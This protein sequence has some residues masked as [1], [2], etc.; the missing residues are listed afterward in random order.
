MKKMNPT[1]FFIKLF[2]LRYMCISKADTFVG[3]NFINSVESVQFKF[4]PIKVSGFDT[5]VFRHT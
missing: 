4:L 1:V 3:G 5:I 2:S